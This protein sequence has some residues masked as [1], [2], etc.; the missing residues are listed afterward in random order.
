MFLDSPPKASIVET[1]FRTI[2]NKMPR[3]SKN[4]QD[5]L[6]NMGEKKDWLS[7]QRKINGWSK[8][9]PD[10]FENINMNDVYSISKLAKEFLN[11][12]EFWYRDF[13]DTRLAFNY[14][15]E[16]FE[17][18]GIIVMKNGIVRNNTHRNLDLDEFRGFLLYDD[19]SPLIFIN[20]KDSDNGMIFTL[21]HEYIHFL[22]QEDDIFVNEYHHN[23]IIDEQRV[24]EITA[25]FLIPT[26]HIEKM[27]SRSKD[28]FEQI[29]E[30]SKYF[31]LVK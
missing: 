6:I 1:E 24:N 17:D 7:E 27:W 26:S 22:L 14:L 15:R 19:Y 11:L 8:I 16:V 28:V 9:I 12:S 2:G 10:S 30:F 23:D 13:K 21:V 29:E 25:E 4:L 31:M 18:K 20:S 3:I 5:T